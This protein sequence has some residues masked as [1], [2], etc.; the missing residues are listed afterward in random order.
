MKKIITELKE[1]AK[2]AKKKGYAVEIKSDHIIAS[3]NNG[4][5]RTGSMTTLKKLVG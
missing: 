1:L 5:I 3:N 4:T 2:L